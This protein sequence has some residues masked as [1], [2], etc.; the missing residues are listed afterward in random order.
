MKDNES[1]IK[2]FWDEKYMSM[3]FNVNEE[4]EG[5]LDLA[6]QDINLEGKRVLIVAVGTG[7]EVVR[8]A[9]SG[10][11][12]YGIDISSC[13]VGNAREMLAA[14]GL[15]GTIVVGD[16]SEPSFDTNFF[17]EYEMQEDSTIKFTLYVHYPNNNYWGSAHRYYYYDAE[18]EYMLGDINFDNVINVIDIVS[19]VN[20]IVGGN[21]GLDD[22]EL[23][24]ADF[25]EDGMV[26]VL[27]VVNIV[28]YILN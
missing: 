8:A 11:Q 15:E 5:D 13:A 14:N 9:R 27:D 26:N 20:Y 17:D 28:N 25:N 2:A 16:A 23:L 3:P 18:P 21:T 6:N 19:L 12:V 7:K 22:L 24:A 10:A 1:G 4:I